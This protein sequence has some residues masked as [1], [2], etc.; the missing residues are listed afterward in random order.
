MH[1]SKPQILG[2]RR[3]IGGGV[4]KPS[5]SQVVLVIWKVVGLAHFEKNRVKQE[6]YGGGSFHTFPLCRV[7]THWKFIQEK[8]KV[9]EDLH[10]LVTF[11]MSLI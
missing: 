8:K 6:S 10:L 1:V 5:F 11:S 3:N 7:S 9:T 4:Q 2:Y